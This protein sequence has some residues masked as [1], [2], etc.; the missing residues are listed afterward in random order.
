PELGE[1]EGSILSWYGSLIQTNLGM[2]ERGN[3]IFRNVTTACLIVR[4]LIPHFLR[5]FRRSCSILF[6]LISRHVS[7]TCCLHPT[8]HL[9]DD[10][11][12]RRWPTT[13]SSDSASAC[14]ALSPSTPQRHEPGCGHRFL[15]Q[16]VRLRKGSLRGQDRRRL[17]A[18][19]VDVL[20]Q[21]AEAPQGG[22]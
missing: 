13:G 7:D 20:R 10:G 17:G 6:C 12:R 14:C 18:E 3:H 15:H 4:I 5:E 11:R 2:P 19:I 21:S 1:G 9:W 22:D 8:V 16:Q